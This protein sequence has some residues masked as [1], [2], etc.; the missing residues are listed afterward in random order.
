V[1]RS[2]KT[3]KLNAGDEFQI[4]AVISIAGDAGDGGGEKASIPP[5]L[6]SPGRGAG[7]HFLT[8]DEKS[9]KISPTQWVSATVRRDSNQYATGADHAAAPDGRVSKYFLR[10]RVSVARSTA[11]LIESVKSSDRVDRR[12]SDAVLLP[13]RSAV[14]NTVW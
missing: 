11:R 1:L 7:W 12:S 8:G 2:V 6:R 10:H 14:G 5:Q 3:L 9:S 4:V 13:L